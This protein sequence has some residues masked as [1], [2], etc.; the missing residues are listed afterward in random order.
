LKRLLKYLFSFL[1]VVLALLA[2]I[3]LLAGTRWGKDRLRDKLVDVANAGLNGQLT[4]GRIEGNLIRTIEIHDILIVADGDTI[5]GL[6]VLA[7]TYDVWGLLRRRVAAGVVRLDSLYV[8]PIQKPDGS[9]NLASLVRHEGPV[10]ED[11]SDA[12]AGWEISVDDLFV[13]GGKL[14]ISP[15]PE[16]RAIPHSVDGLNIHSSISLSGR[17]QLID[18]ESLSL[19]TSDPF[20][21][22]D[23]CSG[24]VRA[25]PDGIEVGGF[26]LQ[27]E[28]NN[29]KLDGLYA[30]GRGRKSSVTLSA[31]RLDVS[32]AAHF[33]PGIAFP[34]K[35]TVEMHAESEND[36][37]IFDLT[38][39]E[40]S[41]RMRV[42]G[43]LAP[44]RNL[45]PYS[46]NAVFERIDIA[47]WIKGKEGA[48][49]LSGRLHLEGAGVTA[50]D[51]N[52]VLTLDIGPS[53]L[54]SRVLDHVSVEAAY[55]SDS[56][57]AVVDVAGSYGNARVRASISGVSREQ[58]FDASIRFLDVNLGK[59][60]LA[61]GLDSRLNLE[62]LARGTGILSG[63]RSGTITC[64]VG[65]SQF[66]DI[67]VD[68]MY[69]MSHLRG[70][71]LLI[72]TLHI[73]SN[74]ANLEAAGKLTM[75][76]GGDLRFG[77]YLK[78][79]RPLK[80]VYNIDT[81]SGTV[82]GEISGSLDSLEAKVRYGL[83]RFSHLGIRAPSVVGD[84]DARLVNG[85]TF[86]AV[87]ANIVKPSY[88]SLVLD[89]SRVRIE[90]R[91]GPTLIDG[92]FFVDKG[93]EGTV[94]ARIDTDTALT[95]SLPMVRL[96]TPGKEWTNGQDTATI[97]IGADVYRIRN[98][99]LR[100]GEE[101]LD[102]SG[103]L[104]PD[105][106]SHFQA[107]VTN[108][109]LSKLSPLWDTTGA[110]QGIASSSLVMRGDYRR[111]EVTDTL[112]VH[113]IMYRS[114][115]IGELTGVMGYA[116]TLAT[117]SGRIVRP[118][119]DTTELEGRIPLRG[120]SSD[121]GGRILARDRPAIVRLHSEKVDLAPLREFL[122]GV[123]ALRGI[124]A[125]DLALYRTD[126]QSEV[127]GSIHLADG[128]VQ[129]PILGVAYTNIAGQLT[130]R[131]DTLHLDSLSMRSSEGGQLTV[132]GTF[133]LP[134]EVRTL[135][136]LPVR[137][138]VSARDFV[139]AKTGEYELKVHGGLAVENNRD[140]T[141]INGI[142]DVQRC[143]VWLPAVLD[144]FR[145]SPTKASLPLLVAAVQRRDTVA[146]SSSLPEMKDSL[147]STLRGVGGRVRVNIPR[148]TWLQSPEI[149]VEISGVLDLS[150]RA[151][152]VEVFG[153][154]IIERGSFTLYGKKFT[155]RNGRLDFEGGANL[156]PTVIIEVEYS[157]RGPEK[158]TEYL[159]LKITGKALK[160]SLEFTHNNERITDKDAISYIMFGRSLDEL[161]QNQKESL[162]SS[163]TDFAQSLA[164]SALSNQLSST[165]GKSLGLDVIEVSLQDNWRAAYLTAGKYVTEKL[166]VRFTQGFQQ[167]QSNEATKEEIALE[168]ELTRIFMLQLIQGTS[169]TTGVNFF[170]ILQ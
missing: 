81:L 103:I 53:R 36:S 64:A 45:I 85:G 143:R 170:L 59:L 38:L 27:T 8:H 153:Y 133:A 84:V 47:P 169:K 43:S 104:C 158:D 44:R 2:G 122:P 164:S 96:N 166:Y 57:D 89:S 66:R 56:L 17:G 127:R 109:D 49:D 93:I 37:V 23:H 105:S 76:G 107:R 146:V 168:Y 3:V 125:G 108:I 135:L 92:R 106:G 151:D 156:D 39:Q 112:R 19:L 41:Q 35:P 128:E 114:S 73:V 78:D 165:V 140:S 52:A 86:A 139:V 65:P 144:Q 155:V 132:A 16:D 24:R 11:S 102:A 61:K 34:L 115:E 6:P 48:S 83:D 95:I 110:L 129:S 163:T 28:K 99:H 116:D 117:W 69:V 67:V 50:K 87:E 145:A 77:G 120:A 119:G 160:P 33:L 88:S 148:N 42:D 31:L 74:Q 123:S 137:L 12:F 94:N 46:L 75:T 90:Y 80:Y 29:L 141:S 58:E 124:L 14:R 121:S 68:T 25:T 113:G 40:A 101:E 147:P 13:N 167:E 111:P 32:E 54:F 22:V 70:P 126:Q 82:A 97:T 71:Y 134:R 91:N 10:P 20:L 162:T 30:P 1:L 131:R 138:D 98:V 152:R 5:L 51:A 79:S 142:I 157:Y 130:G 161:S 9:W 7:V 60:D 159:R 63:Q 18:V 150:P 4:I 62:C 26:R 15:R 21:R 118:N 149:N 55:R 136:D 100:H 154:V 72:D